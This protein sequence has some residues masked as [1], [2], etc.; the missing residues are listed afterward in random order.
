MGE[1]H[2][3]RAKLVRFSLMDYNGEFFTKLTDG[4]LHVSVSEDEL[5]GNRINRFEPYNKHIQATSGNNLQLGKSSAIALAPPPL[6]P[7]PKLTNLQAAPIKFMSKDPG[8]TEDEK[9]GSQDDD[10][11]YMD[12]LG[13]S[14]Q[15]DT[16]EDQLTPGEHRNSLIKSSYQYIRLASRWFHIDHYHPY[17]NVRKGATFIHRYFLI[18]AYRAI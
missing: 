17:L 2:P 12:D 13:D 11:S 15:L 3:R 4:V 8:G 14:E 6:K 1:V 10:D 7:A 9:G 16:S 5:T 18:K